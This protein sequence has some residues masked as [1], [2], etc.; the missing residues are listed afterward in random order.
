MK[1]CIYRI[2]SEQKLSEVATKFNVAE[3]V[4]M[5]KNKLENGE[6]YA[7]MRVI[8]PIIEGEVYVVKPFDTLQ[9]ISK[10]FNVEQDKIKSNNNFTNNSVF[11]GQKLYIPN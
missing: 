4:I 10:K 9:A 8:I 2:V 6:V 3:S 7:G 1:S 5:S 11:V